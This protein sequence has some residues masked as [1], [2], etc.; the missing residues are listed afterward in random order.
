MKR[1]SLSAGVAEIGQDLSSSVGLG[2]RVEGGITDKLV[3][4][5]RHG[6]SL[7][8]DARQRPLLRQAM[9]LMNRSSGKIGS[10]KFLC[11]SSMQLARWGFSEEASA[12]AGSIQEDWF[13]KHAL[14]RL[15]N[16]S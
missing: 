3:G 11:G 1:G 16:P 5:H 6:Q 13:R 12:V 15:R 10:S 14:D 8:A 9:E 7:Q 2:N 4:Q